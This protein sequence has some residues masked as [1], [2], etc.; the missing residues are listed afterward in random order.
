MLGTCPV[1]LDGV[2]VDGHSLSQELM[3]CVHFSLA[4]NTAKVWGESGRDFLGSGPRPSP[5]ILSLTCLHSLVHVLSGLPFCQVEAA[6]GL[7]PDWGA[8][9]LC[10]YPRLFTRRGDKP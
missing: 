8:K 1:T 6:E 7:W 2:W 4:G 3:G 5:Q 10:Y 9:G